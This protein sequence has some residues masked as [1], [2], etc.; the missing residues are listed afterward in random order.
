[1]ICYFVVF[2]NVLAP[3]SSS[4][5]LGQDYLDFI[6][7][8]QGPVVP[9]E[10]AEW[11]AWADAS[12]LPLPQPPPQTFEH[13][14]PLPS[15]PPWAAPTATLLVQHLPRAPGGSLMDAVPPPPPPL[16]PPPAPPAPHPPPLAPPR[17]PLVRLGCPAPASPA[18]RRLCDTG[19][20]CP[21][22][23]FY[24]AAQCAR[25]A[26]WLPAAHW[27]R[28]APPPALAPKGGL[29]RGPAPP[30]QSAKEVREC[31]KLR[32]PYIVHTSCA[33]IDRGITADVTSLL[34]SLSLVLLFCSLCLLI[35][36]PR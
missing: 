17:A 3:S 23:T 16:A 13:E 25:A 14:V 22:P 1:M 8:P 21:R 4:L 34:C 30:G 33:P 9:P 18:V 6:Q 11:T 29:E 19:T 27:R 36:F 20:A 35:P 5:K 28:C 7:L 12:F 26:A 15:R 24:P 31:P 10:W 2:Q 32:A